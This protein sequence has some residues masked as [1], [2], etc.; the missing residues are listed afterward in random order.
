M[1]GLLDLV[2]ETKAMRQVGERQGIAV[3][4]GPQVVKI[5]RNLYSQ[6]CFA[7]KLAMYISEPR[8]KDAKQT[9]V[10]EQA[11]TRMPH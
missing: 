5:Y 8:I 6:L 11:S 4:E 1:P 7:E 3:S 10:L 9:S 2:P